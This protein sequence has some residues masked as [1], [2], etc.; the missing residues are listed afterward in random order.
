MK[1]VD[2]FMYFNCDPR[3]LE[4]M[5]IMLKENFDLLKKGE[6]PKSFGNFRVPTYFGD[7]FS[8]TGYINWRDKYSKSFGFPLISED[9]VK[10]LAKWIGDRPCLEIMAG[11][12]YLSYALSK[13]GVNIKA[14]DNFSWSDYFN[15]SVNVECLD[16]F[17]AIKK[18]GN[19]VD[20]IICS[21]P[22]MDD[23]A[24][25]CL[26]LM[27]KINPKCRMIYIGE[28]FGG[29]TANDRFFNIADFQDIKGFNDAVMNYTR[30]DG[31]HDF[32]GLVKLNSKKGC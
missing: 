2:K 5:R 8:N 9:W 7:P 4:D 19:R 12:G 17:E 30:W 29:C 22:Y 6:I 3:I 13:Y 31:I 26:E 14:T 15:N 28:D 11:T 18:Y 20:F 23:T 10:P 25:L 1:R 32:I 16:C 24:A 21:W 27:F